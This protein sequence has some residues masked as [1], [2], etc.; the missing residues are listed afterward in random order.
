MSVGSDLHRSSRGLQVLIVAY[1]SPELLRQCLTALGDCYPVTVVDNSS[2]AAVRE[3]CDA[4]RTQYLNP[5]RNAGFAAAVNIG[6]KSRQ[7]GSDILLL[8]PD[9]TVC[10]AVVE[11]LREAMR[12]LPRAAC[13]APRQ[14]APGAMAF[15]QVE[16]PFPTPF[17][18]W[19][20]AFGL[21]RFKRAR[22][23]VIGSVLL[24]RDEAIADV[25]LFDERYFLYAE[26]ADWQ[27]RATLRG[28]S[29]HC[30]SQAVAEHL[31]SGTS[32]NARLRDLRFYAAQETYIRKWHGR[33]GWQLYR[34]AI[35]VGA[36]L[37]AMA[38]HR[39]NRRADRSRL[40]TH[41]LGPRSQLRR[42]SS[43]GVTTDRAAEFEALPRPLRV[44]HVVCTEG[45]AGVERYV[46]T[47]AAGLAARGCE[48]TVLGGDPT[49]MRR[50]LE[51]AGVT[52]IAAPTIR[53]AATH[54]WR[55]GQVDV[56]HAHM[57]DAELAAVLG[58][59]RSRARIVATRHFAARRGSSR[60]ARAFGKALSPCLAAQLSISE[61]V[62]SSVEGCS[63]V[64][65]PGVPVVAHLAL[66]R[67]RAKEVL[68]LQR[69]EPEKQVEVGIEAFS[70][71]GLAGLGW[72]L[73]VAGAGSDEQR[74]RGLAEAL[75]VAD[76]CQFLGHQVDVDRLYER[77][78]I[79]LATRPG[80]P[81][82]ISVVEAMAHG[83]P[84]VAVAGGGHAETVGR[85]PGAR[86]FPP[87]DAATAGR[88][89]AELA[90]S[91]ALR[92]RYGAELHDAQRTRFTAD[93]QVEATL[94]V[95]RSVLARGAS[96]LSTSAAAA[97]SA[98][99]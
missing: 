43:R 60:G 76:S 20:T 66:S 67:E 86:M 91:E 11:E 74:L 9:A 26:E 78:A 8:N 25:G 84:I 29:S 73:V 80:E 56:V 62:A 1:G 54:L 50:W 51:P 42:F 47:V 75:G 64:V 36:L 28:W 12:R 14:R 24:L 18:A 63:V 15:D 83:L 10:P 34:A 81:F 22:G 65:P 46:T 57:Y 85:C 7:E 17:D 35:V 37:R 69:L 3:I 71:S 70:T 99:G 82:G 44:V 38:P 39:L 96:A 19:C 79:F 27:R 52:W 77:A 45:F 72:H 61:F 90:A 89:L 40:A 13:V 55:I 59:P 97:T 95:Y 4:A 48:V 32:S 88:F 93:A 53:A 49:Q 5:G 16:W 41:L 21:A 33:I 6:L 31:G 98:R 2:S 94:E 30:V 58:R 92:D 68:M 23:F 87:G